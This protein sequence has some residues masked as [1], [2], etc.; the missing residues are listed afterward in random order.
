MSSNEKTEKLD[1]KFQLFRD[2]P[3]EARDE[4]SNMA[5]W[6]E[7]NEGNSLFQQGAPGLGIY[8]LA[9]GEVEQHHITPQGKK[10]IFELSG[11]GSVIGSETLFNKENHIST[12]EVTSG[13]ASVGFLE[14]NNFF[15]FMK[16]HPALL[17]GF[18]DYLATQ[19]MA[20]KLKLV[21]A[22]YL[23]SKQRISRLILS[24][25]DCD[26]SLS[27]TD[28]AQLTG[29]SYKTAIQVLGE[30]EERGLIETKEH[31]IEAVYIDG[32]SKLANDISLEME[33]GSLL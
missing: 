16:D 9:E 18:A 20:N 5:S 26:I 29:V 1:A 17:F 13:K 22:S 24:S 4:L 10:L 14:R 33:V 8:L 30:L 2:L 27:R 11:P 6:F 7:T 31:K 19:T 12:A 21:E 28:L 15:E 32:L 25:N 23:G 3:P